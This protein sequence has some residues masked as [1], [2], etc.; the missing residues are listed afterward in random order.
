MCDG[1]NA[2]SAFNRGL[3]AQATERIS[4]KFGTEPLL[5][6]EMRGSMALVAL[7][8]PQADSY[9]STSAKVLQDWLHKECKIECPI[10]CVEGELFAR[11]S[12]HAYNELDEYD[13]LADAVLDFDWRRA[14][15]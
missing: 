14:C 9:T 4:A 10:K 3:C 6:P 8:A 12:A 7:P 11:I 2:L 15:E 13:I 5:P 1:I